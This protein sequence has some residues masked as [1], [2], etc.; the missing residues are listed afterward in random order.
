MRHVAQ[1]VVADRQ[2]RRRAV[3]L[4]VFRPATPLISMTPRLLPAL[5]LALVLASISPAG[6]AD[7]PLKP[8]PAPDLSKLPAK[9]AEDLR[10]ARASFDKVREHQTGEVL[11]ESYGLLGTAYARQGFHDAAAVA[12][13]DAIALA[14]RA[15]RWLY[16]RA[17]LANAQRQPAAARGFL[18]RA[19]AQ[20]ASYLPIRVALA[21]AKIEAGDLDG[22][23]TLL[24]VVAKPDAE[25]AVPF[26][27]LGDIALR[28][29]RYA[30]AVERYQRA[31]AL[32]PQ[33]TRLQAR[34]AEAYTGAGNAKAAAEAR[35]KAGEAAPK[36]DDP[37]GSSLI[38]ASAPAADL[39]SD[40]LA[41]AIAEATSLVAQR[42][43]DAARQRLDAALKQKP[44][45]PYLLATLARIDAAAGD[46]AAA[47]THAAAAVAAGPNDA[48]ALLAQAVVAEM[49]GD[50][51]GAEAGY[52]KA[53]G[54][55]TRLVEPRLRLA[56]LLLRTAR[57]QAAAEQYRA[58]LTLEPGTGAYLMRLVAAQAAAGRCADALKDV[59]AAL[60]KDANSPFLLELFVR[61]ASTCP[62]VRAEEKR[63]A[64]D[65]A[66]KIYRAHEIAPIGEAY[67]LALAASGKWD[68]AV[69]TQEGAMFLLV[70]NGRGEE[71]PAYREF[72][73]QF[74]AHKLPDRPWPASSPLYQ[75][76]RPAPDPKPVAATP[77]PK[78]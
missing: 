16:L 49:A 10:A 11:A 46:L 15:A 32:D 29:R 45:D 56:D 20:N 54:R 14:P 42:Q 65:Y 48:L 26:A 73:D 4:R 36:L 75:P 6:A 78:K 34:L 19:F 60:A 23:R 53:I 28:Q 57:P 43:Y 52:G 76:Q 24:E 9:Q 74:K 77:A 71:L 72:L 33:A 1:P 12:F 40:P 68:D 63:M 35:A 50:D 2:R 61:V 17:L 70:R 47:K 66:G 27:M 39:P 5:A 25:A 59:N 41:R 55:D 38:G 69:K 18:E 8:V 13:D 30:E 67:A 51:Q 31:L 3:T 22:A 21:S 44:N 62:A 58:L 37:V 7:A 64:F